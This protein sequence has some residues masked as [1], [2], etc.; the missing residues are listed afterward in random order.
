MD[1]KAIPFWLLWGGLILLNLFILVVTIVSACLLGN[2][3]DNVFVEKERFMNST[4][5]YISYYNTMTGVEKQSEDVPSWVYASTAFLESSYRKNGLEK[6][7]LGQD[8]YVQFD[9]QLFYSTVKKLCTQTKNKYCDAVNSNSGSPE[10]LFYLSKIFGDKLNPAVAPSGYIENPSSSPI[11]F[12]VNGINSVYNDFKLRILMAETGLP[13]TLNFGVFKRRY[14]IPCTNSIGYTCPDSLTKIPCPTS[15]DGLCV[16]FSY[17]PYSQSG[18]Y[19]F[20]GQ[21]HYTDKHSVL[22]VGWNDEKRI[23]RSWGSDLHNFVDGG[24][25]VKNSYG[26]Q[27]GHS[28][29]FWL[30]QHS[31]KE[32]MQICPNVQSFEQWTPMDE[33]CMNTKTYAEC[34][35]LVLKKGVK[36]YI[37]ASITPLICDSSRNDKYKGI[38]QCDQNRLYFIKSRKHSFGPYSSF[39]SMDITPIQ[40]TNLMS[41]NLLSFNKDMTDKQLITIK[42]TCPEM[43]EDI[44]T[45]YY[46]GN[47]VEATTNTEECGYDFIPFEVLEKYNQNYVVDGVHAPAFSSFDIAWDDQSYVKKAASGPNYEPLKAGTKK[48]YQTNFV[49][50]YDMN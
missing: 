17:N 44:F 1:K 25:I 49:G 46:T 23:D 6:G 16:S 43:L 7:F 35:K 45:T 20:I 32:E 34:C 27:H 30:Q 36:R 5:K 38:F 28:L 22:V 19:D 9:E 42:P 10:L 3:I 14:Y 15:S 37:E 29:K 33:E 24:Y 18:V 41:I 4:R 48:I 26:Y 40:N 11:K 47:D 13:F 31:I 50:P 2:E 8:E 12:Q 21:L 39:G